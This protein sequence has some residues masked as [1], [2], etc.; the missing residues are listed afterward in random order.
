MQLEELGWN[1]DRAS[2]FKSCADRGLAPARVARQD[3]GGFTVW[4]HD[5]LFPAALA[6]RLRH[7]ADKESNTVAVVTPNPTSAN[8]KTSD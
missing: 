1:A 6:G 3:R 2:A 8:S 5:G 7:G 4:S